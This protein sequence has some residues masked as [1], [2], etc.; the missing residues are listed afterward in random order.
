MLVAAE[1]LK[2]C[3]D[4]DHLV[5]KAVAS[6]ADDSLITE[7]LSNDI[8]AQAIEKRLEAHHVLDGTDLII[9]AHAHCY[10]A[11][12]A[13]A[14]FGAI[15]YHPSLLPL[16]RSCDAVAWAIHMHEPVAGGSVYWMDNRADGGPVIAQ[17][18]CFIRPGDTALVFG[19]EI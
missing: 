4:L 13:R 11:G 15:G 12:G 3:V 1:T 10:I 6:R 18:W 17:G 9:A 8:H 2:F 16:H 14:R 7:A 19:E 5:V